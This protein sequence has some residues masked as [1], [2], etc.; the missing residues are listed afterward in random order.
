M[1]I[2]VSLDCIPTAQPGGGIFTTK[3][4]KIESTEATVF[5]SYFIKAPAA[6]IEPA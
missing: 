3:L 1:P 2:V 6:G 4:S 5:H